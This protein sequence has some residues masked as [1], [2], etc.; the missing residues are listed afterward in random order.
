M[1]QLDLSGNNISS[2]FNGTNINSVSGNITMDNGL[3]NLNGTF[4]C[5]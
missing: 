3:N 4:R 1:L 5:K 2:V